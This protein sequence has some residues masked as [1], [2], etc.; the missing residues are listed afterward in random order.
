M[1]V[2]DDISLTASRILVDRARVR[3]EAAIEALFARYHERL[4][5]ALRRRLGDE[6]RRDLLDSE[7]AVHDGVVAALRELENFEYAGEGSF[8]AWLLRIAEHRV[9]ERLRAQRT[10]KRDRRRHSALTSAEEI[11][12]AGPSP[13]EVASGRE[14][15]ERIQRALLKMDAREREVIVLRRYF[16]M[17]TEEIR[18]A[19]G[20]PTAGAVRALLSR[21]QAR[22]AALLDLGAA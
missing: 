4:R 14:V 11:A 13:S 19:M 2:P 3:D 17:P 10:L 16:E 9:V 20:L 22:L 6:Y 15:E 18:D 5:L 21:A 7:D 1:P 12:A 8:L